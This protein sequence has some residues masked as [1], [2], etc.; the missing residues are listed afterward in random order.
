MPH[1]I[2]IYVR[3]STEEQAQVLEGS[4]E[5]QQHRLKGFVELKNS[6]E[7]RWGKVVDTY[8]DDGYSAKD[9]K[10][11]AYQRMMK[12]IRSGKINLILVP[13]I[14]RLS[15]NIYDFCGLLKELDELKAKFFSVK[16]QFDT[17]TPAGEMMIYNMINLAQFERKQTSERVSLNFHSRALR[18]LLN[19]GPSMLGFDKD[20]ANSGKFVVNEKEVPGVKAIF[21]TYL[22]TGSLQATAKALNGTGIKPKMPKGKNYRHVAEGRWTTNSVRNHLTNFSYV[23]KREVNRKSKNEDKDFLKPW[24]QYQIVD[25]A[26]PAIID[27]K[28][29]Y[30][31]QR[32]IAEN[33][34]KERH[35]FKDVQRRVFLL[36]GIL[37]CGECGMALIGQAAHGRSE[38]HRY[39]G[40]KKVVGENIVCKTKRF[41][42]DEI[43]TVVID[44]LD[45]ILWRAGRFDDIEANIRKMIGA[46]G[47]DLFAERDRVQRELVALD[48][49]IESAFKLH[50]EMG[51]N[52]EVIALI[53]EKLEKLA[54][55][56]KKLNHYRDELLSKIEKNADA[57][58]ARSVIEDHARA[59]KKGWAKANVSVQ[60]RLIRRLLDKLIFRVDGLY[61]YYVTDKDEEFFG[62]AEKKNGKASESNSGASLSTLNLKGLN[63]RGTTELLSFG[64]SPVVY[65]GGDGGSRTHVRKRSTSSFYMRSNSF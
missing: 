23:G 53:K 35:R 51:S 10:R 32:L 56:K 13:D 17:S 43:E 61:T 39:Y 45:E 55:Q 18:G 60:K 64:G 2:G 38:V 28:T 40:H 44:H 20:P 11:P 36:S 65:S 8:I 49:D 52:Q 27:E 33:R 7:G 15:R 22:E 59:F 26:W 50:L 46:S 25:A 62:N 57:K 9:T 31:A 4:I 58:E 34:E 6:H 19:G 14:S 37:R 24:Q 1:K 41:R 5:N 47:A 30:E 3:V 12:D 29:Y 48:K 63:T 21:A 42:A 16:E 54:D